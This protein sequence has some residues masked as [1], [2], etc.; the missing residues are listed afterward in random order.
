MWSSRQGRCWHGSR[1]RP[2]R[3]PDVA[4]MSLHSNTNK[5]PKTMQSTLR[6]PRVALGWMT[7]LLIAVVGL[8]YVKWFPY[9]NRAFV[10]A[11]QHSI[12]KSILLGTAA[13]APAPSSR[14]AID[15]PFGYVHASSQA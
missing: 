2:S 4:L 3:R 15:Y 8:F 7:F 5:L 10:A 13:S 14:S 6:Q 1:P 9:Y 11:S 12:G